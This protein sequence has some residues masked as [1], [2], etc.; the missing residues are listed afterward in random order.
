MVKMVYL[1]TVCVLHDKTQAV[2]CLEGVF[3]SLQ[4]EKENNQNRTWGCFQLIQEEV[5]I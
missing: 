3:Q 2:M 1:T 5:D 4:T